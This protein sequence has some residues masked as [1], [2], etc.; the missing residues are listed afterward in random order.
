MAASTARAIPPAMPMISSRHT[1]ISLAN[2]YKA[3]G[4]TIYSIG[5]ALGSSVNC[6]AGGFRKKNSSGNWVSC[7]RLH[8]GLLPLRQH[9]GREPRDHLVQHALADRL[10]R[11]LLQP[12]ERRPAQHDL[13]RDRD[14]HRPGLEPAR[15]RRLLTAAAQA[16]PSP[17]RARAPAAALCADSDLRLASAAVTDYLF[18]GDTE[19]WRPCV[20]S[21]LLRFWIPF[22][23]GIVG[24]RM[25]VMASP[26]EA[27][28]I[29][30]AAPEAVVHDLAAL[31]LSECSEWHGLAW[32]RPGA[33][34]ARAR[35][36]VCGRP[37]S[38][39]KCR[40]VADRCDPTVSCCTRSLG[41]RISPARE[42]GSRAPAPVARELRRG[43]NAG[44]G[45]APAPGGSQRGHLIS[46]ESC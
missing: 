44:G 45:G 23:L 8:C 12:A 35:Q 9:H 16:R 24:G 18:Y 3:A 26:L 2:S 41:H 5:Y 29:A 21:S 19:R 14:R 27:E 31:G 37:S 38:I 4:T 42:I 17:S 7:S 28:R 11:R 32:P 40:C 13:R 10:A 1:A 46:G 33:D 20:T 6:T 36:W 43:R 25:H 22:L 39:P 15:R 34:V 30:A